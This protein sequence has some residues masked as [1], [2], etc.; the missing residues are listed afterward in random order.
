MFSLSELKQTRFYQDAFR[1][2][3]IAGKLE[4]VPQL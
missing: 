2:G 4:S 1:E 3:E